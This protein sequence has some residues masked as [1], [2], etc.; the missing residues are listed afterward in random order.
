MVTTVPAVAC[1]LVAHAPVQAGVSLDVPFERGER[2]AVILPAGITKAVT[3]AGDGL[4][5]NLASDVAP[6][7]TWFPST[8]VSGVASWSSN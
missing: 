6:P 1:T 2:L 7:P 8:K 5:I 3:A 4:K